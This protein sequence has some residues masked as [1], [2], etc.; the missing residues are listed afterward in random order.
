MS[1][2]L[3]ATCD[4]TGKVTADGVVV[5]AAVVLSEGKQAS[6]GILIL[7]GDV[8]R[9]LPSSATDIKTVIE[10][11]ETIL[12]DASAAFTSIGAQLTALG[13]DGATATA[14]A[15]SLLATKALLTTLKG[16]LK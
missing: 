8:V 16:A 10:K 4:A 7:E 2:V 9:Y 6:S 1:K 11:L 13:G 14:K 15:T 5:T 12:D 3:P